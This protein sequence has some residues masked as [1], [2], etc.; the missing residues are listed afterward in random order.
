MAETNP[1]AVLMMAHVKTMATQNRAKSR[2]TWKLWLFRRLLKS[3]YKRHDM[4]ALLN[5]VDWLMGLPAP[6]EEQLDKEVEEMEATKRVPYMT[7]WERRGLKKGR[8]EGLKKGLEKGREEGLEKGLRLGKVETL[9]SQAT[10]RFGEL[11]EDVVESLDR[12]DV[13]T[14]DRWLRKL[15]DA[16]R[17]T[18]V[19]GDDPVS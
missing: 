5:F 2:Y 18:D 3:R 15:L 14:L 4:E 6:F 7:P 13:D 10:Q 19:F 12:A 11:P 9:K 8:K 17:L 16:R 1:F